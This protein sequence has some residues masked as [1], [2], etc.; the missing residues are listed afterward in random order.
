MNDRDKPESIT[1]EKH[2]RQAIDAYAALIAHSKLSP[3]RY[4]LVVAMIGWRVTPLRAFVS[5]LLTPCIVLTGW[6][7]IVRPATTG[8]A[9]AIVVTVMGVL[10]SISLALG[11]THLLL[12]MM[13]HGLDALSQSIARLKQRHQA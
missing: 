7:W 10:F 9:P 12:K 4:W 6:L 5:D 8:V 1:P 3:A 11:M 2:Q 13:Q